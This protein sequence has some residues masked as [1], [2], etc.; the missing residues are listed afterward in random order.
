MTAHP[1]LPEIGTAIIGGGIVGTCL[2]AFLAKDGM[3]AAIVDA[4][5]IGGTTANAGSF[6]V[7]MQS[8]FM[9]LYPDLVPGLESTLHLYPKAV[10]FW[11]AL[12]AEL[13]GGFDLKVTGGL[14]VAES[15][16]A[17]RFPRLQGRARAK[18]RARPS[19][20]STAPRWSGSPPISA[21]R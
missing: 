7:Q 6:H 12:E 14:M 19:T 2:A 5:R 3:D 1:E 9:R 4:G 18:T 15:P 21:R 20:S 16:R 10:R 17:A 13:G 8:R 11:Q